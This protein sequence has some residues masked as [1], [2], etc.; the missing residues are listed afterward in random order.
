MVAPR[1]GRV[2]EVRMRAGD[3]V[4]RGDLLVVVVDVDAVITAA[5]P[6]AA[7]TGEVRS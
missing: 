7:N 4:A 6:D 2:S 5:A 3:Q 1:P